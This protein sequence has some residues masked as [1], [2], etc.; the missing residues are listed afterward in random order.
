MSVW[1]L[2]RPRGGGGALRCGVSLML[3]LFYSCTHKDADAAC[4]RD[5]LIPQRHNG[6]SHTHVVTT[7]VTYIYTYIYYSAVVQ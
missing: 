1:F 4:K 5:R 7:T 3:V 6:A 2:G